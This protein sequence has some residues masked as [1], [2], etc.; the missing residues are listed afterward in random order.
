MPPA[1]VDWTPAAVVLSVGVVLGLFFIWRAVSAGRT[2]V[3]ARAVP[4]LELRD[5]EAKRDALILQ[6]RELEDT[7]AKRSGDQLA[8][9]RYALELE[10]A[11]AWRALDERQLTA[12][13]GARPVADTPKTVAEA[14]V[15]EP[16]SAWKG[17]LWG[18]GS[19][20]AVL[21]LVMLVSRSAEERRD[22]GSPT[23]GGPMAAGGAE[24]GDPEL[25][26]L[27]AAVAARPDDLAARLDLAR[28][29]LMRQDM[30]GVFEQTQAVLER[31]PENPRALA[32][33]A[34]VR[35][36]MG[37]SDQAESMLKRAIAKDPDLVDGYVHLMLVYLNMGRGRDAEAT[38]ATASK[39]FPDQAQSLASLFGQM[40]AAAS[41]ASEAS[42]TGTAAAPASASGGATG[43]AAAPAA[44]G[45]RVT[46]ILSLDPSAAAR[47]GAGGVVYVML[48]PA[49]VREGPPLAAIRLPGSGFP[50]AFAIGD[51]DAMTGDP[52]PDSVLVEARLDRDGDVATRDAGDPYGSADGIALGTANLQIVLK[53]RD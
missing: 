42:T 45:R 30:M 52:I 23:G 2:A 8:S 26:R 9:E 13:S 51:A 37:Q 6:L 1:Q 34:L 47:L 7:A 43:S 49:G 21:L 18:V 41:G 22:R 53:P 20:S 14:A 33:Q 32:Y 12:P 15:A 28:L 4:D 11:R 29:Q 39:K 16:P 19:V 31:E 50:L 44:S 36:A 10:A 25:E 48:R 38:L 40:R 27:Q 24:A 3:T 5:L 46:G 17:F 35:M